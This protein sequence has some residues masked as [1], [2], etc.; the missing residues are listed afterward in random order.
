[1]EVHSLYEKKILLRNLL[2][3]IGLHCV[4]RSS[5]SATT[6]ATLVSMARPTYALSFLAVTRIGQK[7]ARAIFAIFALEESL[8]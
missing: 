1:M 2:I 7:L 4:E 3:F 6:L 5:R 8:E